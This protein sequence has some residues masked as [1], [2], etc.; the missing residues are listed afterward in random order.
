VRR[1]SLNQSIALAI[2]AIIGATAS[3]RAASPQEDFLAWY[4]EWLDHLPLCYT[5]TYRQFLN[6]P[7]EAPLETTSSKWRDAHFQLITTTNSE[8]HKTFRFLV[9]PSYCAAVDG[10]VGSNGDIVW[11]IS[12]F[13]KRSDSAF[14]QTMGF[15]NR[16]GADPDFLG[17]RRGQLAGPLRIS[18][19]TPHPNRAGVSNLVISFLAPDRKNPRFPT[20]IT[21]AL[22]PSNQSLPVEVLAQEVGGARSRFKIGGWHLQGDAWV[23]S[24]I[25]TFYQRAGASPEVM[26]STQS[27]QF[28]ANSPGREEECYLSYYGLSEPNTSRWPWRMAAIACALVLFTGGYVVRNHSLGK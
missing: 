4:R 14:E 11:N 5:Q 19:P 18:G 3:A 13:A 16:I 15:A 9:N 27:W 8:I 6:H 21:V 2:G 17:S 28:D 20:R 1:I 7:V 22:D 23:F 25:R 24:D 10:L 12:Q 26:H